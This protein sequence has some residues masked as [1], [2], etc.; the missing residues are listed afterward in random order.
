MNTSLLAEEIAR[1]TLATGAAAA[2]RLEVLHEIWGSGTR[3]TAIS[4]GLSPGMKVAD[5]G[6]GVGTVSVLFS[7]IV[8]GE[9]KVTALDMSQAQLE[10]ARARAAKAGHS[11]IEFIEGNATAT[12]L[13]DA[14]FDFV[15]CRF[16]LLHLPDPMAGL[17]EMRRVLR[18]GGTL[19]V[20]DGDLS[21]GYT[22]PPSAID[23]FS[24]L[25]PKLGVAR[26]LDYTLGRR[27]HQL[28]RDA[29]FQELAVRFNQPAYFHGRERR[30]FEWSLEEA[31]DALI[32]A[33][34]CSREELDAILSEMRTAAA[35]PAILVAVPRMS[36]VT[37]R[38]PE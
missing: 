38:K 33:G 7:E 23:R 15:Y 36:L 4:A 16:L 2:H 26:G 24:E 6:C 11:N 20:E 21:S 9:G 35:D 13:P 1:Y 37:A 27:V 32:S 30:A 12:D 14:S 17:T 10:Q 18:P 29:G 8:G 19:F 28:V 31:A 22:V 3:Q 34:L 5:F 25:Y